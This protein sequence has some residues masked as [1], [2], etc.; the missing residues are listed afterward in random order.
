MYTWKLLAFEL[1]LE[2]WDDFLR[3]ANQVVN[4]VVPD[5]EIN[6]NIATELYKC[7]WS[8]GKT[9]QSSVSS[10]FFLLT[11]HSPQGDFL[12]IF[13]SITTPPHEIKHLRMKIWMCT[14]KLQRPTTCVISKNS[15]PTQNDFIPF[16]ENITPF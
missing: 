14:F 9:I 2:K 16:G 10:I 1:Y 4:K 15:L 6:M 5:R 12:E 13:F 11:L 7:M 8:Q 3:R